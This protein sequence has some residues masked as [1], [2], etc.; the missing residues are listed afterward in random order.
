LFT[1]VARFTSQ[2]FDWALPSQLAYPAVQLMPHAPS[3]QLGVPLLPEHT[4]PQV[5]QLLMLVWVFASQPL[6]G[7]PSQLA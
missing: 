2:P 4:V 5:P 7:L 6:F 1:F 3:A